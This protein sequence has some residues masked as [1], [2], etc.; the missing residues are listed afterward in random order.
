MPYPEDVGGVE[1]DTPLMDAAFLLTPLPPAVNLA[2][3]RCRQRPRHRGC[4]HLDRAGRRLLRLALGHVLT[5]VRQ[6]GRPAR[7]LLQC[8]VR[9]TDV[10]ALAI[11]P[12]IWPPI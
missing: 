10:R 1:L 12:P 3:R 6:A 7:G 5:P 2:P 11:C 9:G 8:Y 4:R